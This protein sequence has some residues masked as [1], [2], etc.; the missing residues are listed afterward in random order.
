MSGQDG[1]AGFWKRSEETK[2]AGGPVGLYIEHRLKL[3]F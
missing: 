2:K 1:T 3:D